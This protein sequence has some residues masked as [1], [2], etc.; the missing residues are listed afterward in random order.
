MSDERLMLDHE[1]DGIREL[2]ND[3]PRWWVWLFYITIF[4]AAVYLLYYHVF[5]IGYLS[6]DEYLQEVDP[7]YTRVEPAGSKFMG[8]VSEYHP[9]VYDPVR[10]YALMG[11]V[12]KKAAVTFKVER[13]ETDTTTYVALTDPEN[14]EH[15]KEIF[16]LR[17]ASCHGRLG[18]GNIGPNLTDDYWLHG[19][20]M[21]N[22]VKT[23]KYGVPAKGMLSWRGELK[24]DEIMQAASYILTLHG[25]A[26][27]NAKAPQGEL[28][29]E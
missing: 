17:C 14:L 9:P 27:P 6:R 3:L 19:A 12:K 25:T 1:Y 29:T 10:D 22:V 13:R 2:D 28:V 20:G 21:S 4:W 18:E 15:G 8:L 23:I 24:P 7:N 5:A 26:P 16:L 11:G